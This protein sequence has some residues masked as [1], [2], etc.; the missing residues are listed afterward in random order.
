MSLRV[1]IL[2]I[3][4]LLTTLSLLSGC[5]SVVN[6]FEPD[7]QV[8]Y[9]GNRVSMKWLMAFKT[10]HCMGSVDVQNGQ[11]ANDTV[12]FATQEEVFQEVERRNRIEGEEPTPFVP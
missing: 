1:P 11:P 10:V 6:P 2:Y 9:Y 8:L 5:R 7:Q 12:C 4:A 3:V